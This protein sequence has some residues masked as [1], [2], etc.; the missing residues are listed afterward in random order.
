MAGRCAG[1]LDALQQVASSPHEHS[2]M[3]GFAAVLKLE[4]AERR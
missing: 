4:L 1:I 3:R 2:D